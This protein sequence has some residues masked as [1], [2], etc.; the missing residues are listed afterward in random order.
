V[1][2]GLARIHKSFAGRPVLDG[3]SLDL[4]EGKIV[5]LLGPSGVGKSTVLRIAA[6]LI[7]PDAGEVNMP[8]GACA[9]VFQE[10]RLLPWLTVAGNLAL[11]LPFW[12]RKREA[13][14]AA[15]ARVRMPGARALMPS[16]LS[17]GMAQRVGIARALLREPRA[18]LM[19]EPFAALDAITRAGHQRMLKRLIEGGRTCCLF[20]THDIHEAMT[21]GDRIL[22]MNAGRIAAEFDP[23]ENRAGL[24]QRI[25][26]HLQ[27]TEK[28]KT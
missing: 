23:A 18:L 3:V 9:M 16:A 7:A 5:C 1:T 2:I 11:A 14:D 24:E 6:G 10:P 12:S 25:L 28:E 20:V 13:I 27:T 15:L 17:G 8:P 22:V 26:D 19:D 21:I 4:A